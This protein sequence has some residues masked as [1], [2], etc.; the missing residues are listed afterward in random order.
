MK[1]MRKIIL[2]SNSPRGKELLALLQINFEVIVSQV[3]EVIDPE[4]SET[5]LVMDLAFQKAS[6]IFKTH[7]E[8]LVLGFDTLVY[9]EDEVLGKPKTKE[10][11]KMMLQKLSGNT[12]TVI[13][14]CALITKLFSKSFYE[15]ARVTFYPLSEQE[16]EDY[17]DTKEPFDKA[18]AYGVQGYGSKFI[19]SIV[20]DFYTI[21]G[22]PIARLYHEL[23]N[24]N[25]IDN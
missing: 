14:G 6:D 12:H 24:A 21:M 7:K 2:A 11:A 1:P 19:K 13:T 20:G 3:E 25:L 15:K 16:I 5:E 9:L 22:L 4:L 23:Q 8:D 17:I 18:G 10:E